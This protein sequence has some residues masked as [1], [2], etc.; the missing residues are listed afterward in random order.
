MS[1]QHSATNLLLQLSDVLTQLSD[2][3]YTCSLTVLSGSSLGQHFR[4]T[5][6]FFTC[7]IDGKNS[8]IVNY[9]LRKRD[10]TIETE[11]AVALAL[12][13]E[14]INELRK[15]NNDFPID[16]E[17]NYELENDHVTIIKSTYMRELAYNIEHTIH[18]MAL[19]KIGIEFLNP[20]VR[21]PVHFGIASSTVKH[22]LQRH[23]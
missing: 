16:F 10:L 4:H 14:I 19:M 7:L 22:Q 5:L 17:A 21:L 12:I 18:H 20:S 8:G 9:D 3:E 13:E 15:S 6:E 23:H 11:R 1:L 2:E